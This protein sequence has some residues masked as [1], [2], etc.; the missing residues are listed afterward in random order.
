MASAPRTVPIRDVAPRRA[1]LDALENP[2]DHAP[3][4]TVGVTADR[5][6][7]KV[8]LQGV[9]LEVGQVGVARQA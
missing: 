1:G 6:W 9:P 4:V 5:I 3:I 8:R 2:L 7:G